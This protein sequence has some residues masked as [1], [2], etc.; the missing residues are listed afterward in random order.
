VS[1]AQLRAGWGAA[2]WAMERYLRA[3]NP[4]VSERIRALRLE[5]EREF[6]AMTWA[7]NRVAGP[8]LLW[9]SKRDA[10]QHPSGR[11]LEPRTFVER[12]V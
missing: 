12:H 11:R 2:L 6:G 7:I 4:S 1:G 10:R 5:T 8:A 9:S 3:G